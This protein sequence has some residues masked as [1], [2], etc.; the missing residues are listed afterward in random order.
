MLLRP[1]AKC[2]YRKKKKKHALL[3]A[4]TGRCARHCSRDP[5]E[6][7]AQPG[8]MTPAHAGTVAV[9]ASA[10]WPSAEQ[11]QSF[12][13]KKELLSHK[14]RPQLGAAAAKD[15]KSSEDHLPRAKIIWRN[16]LSKNK[17]VQVGHI[18]QR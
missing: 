7:Q 18:G 9:A 8:A 15:L 10:L 5:Q 17:L 3:T 13:F 11:Q 14:Q 2:S 16:E 4:A 1:Q 12:E 6:P